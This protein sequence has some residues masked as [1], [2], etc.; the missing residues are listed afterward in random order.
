MAQN[1]LTVTPENPT[2]PTNFGVG[3]ANAGK[4]TPGPPSVDYATTV[5]ND[6]FHPGVTNPTGPTPP[7]MST[8][9]LPPYLDDGTAGA[10]SAF[11]A[12]NSGVAS[13]GAGTEVIVTATS[14]NPNP[15]GQLTTVSDLGSY[16]NLITGGPNTQHASSLNAAGTST[17]TSVP[18]GGVHPSVPTTVSLTIT[19]TNFRRDSVVNIGGVPQV[20]NYV[21]ATSLTVANAQKLTAAGSTP[22]TVTTGGVTT[23]PTNWTFT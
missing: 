17:I 18:A 10:L 14:P 7:G 13:E 23:A 15:I 20:T 2:P 22:V 12:P 11:A 1:A 8:S 9:T 19:G 5:Y 4:F 16:T 3:I 6:Q 21:S